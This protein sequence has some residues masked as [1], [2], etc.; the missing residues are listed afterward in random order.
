MYDPQLSDNLRIAP[1]GALAAAVGASA[2][3][4]ELEGIGL[5]YKG[6]PG[7]I[8]GRIGLESAFCDGVFKGFAAFNGFADQKALIPVGN[9]RAAACLEDCRID[10]ERRILN[11]GSIE[12]P[13]LDLTAGNIKYPVSAVRAAAPGRASASDLCR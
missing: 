5:Y 6:Y 3:Y 4:A 13:C 9:N 1:H 8:I 10:D 12:G 11:L 2:V 7:G